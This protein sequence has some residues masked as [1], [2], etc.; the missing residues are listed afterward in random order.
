MQNIINNEKSSNI[1]NQTKKYLSFE[2][3][4]MIEK[5][6]KEWLS[7]RK[8]WWILWRW[9]ST[10]WDEIKNNSTFHD[11]YKAELAH[12]KFLQNQLKKRN[13]DKI[14][15]NTKLQEYIISKLKEDWSP[16]EISWRLKK[17]HNDKDLD[18]YIWYVCF[19]TIYKFIYSKNWIKFWLPRLLRRHKHKRT[20]WYS[21]KSRSISDVI[22]NRVSIHSR[23]KVINARKRIGDFESDSVIFSNQKQV[24]NVNVDRKSRLLRFEL[25][26]DKTA[27]SSIA[28][29][30]KIVYEFE[31]YWLDIYSFTY[32]NWTENVY[33]SEL[34]NFWVKTY[35]CDTYSSWQKWTVENM[36]MF[37]RQY[38]PKNTDLS[39]LTLQDLQNIQEKLNNRPRKCLNYLS[40]NEFFY[41]ETWVK[42]F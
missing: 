15:T 8:I 14:E 22:K 19:E 17:F 30:K 5:M 23:P 27:I 26:E 41:K 9:K 20:K 39:K 31:E 12:K 34:H 3:R 10:I 21:R 24:L 1:K 25:V 2:E 32:D 6:I 7:L 4:R 13:K 28:V 36:N 37:I 33:H 42:L 11:W 40:P 16:E 38:L 35:F 29:Q 18:S